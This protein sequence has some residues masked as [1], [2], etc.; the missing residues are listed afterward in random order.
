M[1]VTVVES[2]IN[3]LQRQYEDIAVTDSP[4]IYVHGYVI[5]GIRGMTINKSAPFSCQIFL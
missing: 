3:F 4:S 5:E 1:E 2:N